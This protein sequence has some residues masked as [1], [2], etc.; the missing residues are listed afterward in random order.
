MN[1]FELI[2]QWGIER[3]LYINGDPKTQTLKLMEEIG[4]LSRSLLKN[5]REDT[6]DAVGDIVIVLT[7][8]CILL[9]LDIMECTEKAYEVIK[10]RKGKMINNTFVKE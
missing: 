8:L 6:V 4:E 5:N 3:N 10:D 9:N 2:K 1:I 7:N